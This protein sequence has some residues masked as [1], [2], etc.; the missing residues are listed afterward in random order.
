[1]A[2]NY[3]PRVIN[4]LPLHLLKL[5]CF[6]FPK[7][8]KAKEMIKLVGFSFIEEPQVDEPSKRRYDASRACNRLLDRARPIGMLVRPS[9]GD[10]H[11]FGGLVFWFRPSRPST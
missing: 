8:M 1:M 11:E 5:N 6:T 3:L 7:H 10:E 4:S 9:A 2:P